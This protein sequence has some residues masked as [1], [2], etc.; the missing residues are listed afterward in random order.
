LTWEKY[1]RFKKFIVYQQEGVM[2]VNT[3]GVLLGAW[4][5][6]SGKENVVLDAGS[7][8]GI[9][10]LMLLQRGCKNVIALD[11][12]EKA[13]FQTRENIFT[14][15]SHFLKEGIK[16]E[17]FC[18][19]FQ[20]FAFE[21]KWKE[22]LDLVVS[23]PPYYSGDLKSPD[24]RKNRH[25]HQA[26]L[27]WE[28]FFSGSFNLLKNEGRCVFICPAKDIREIEKLWM[29]KGFHCQRKTSLYYK[30]GRTHP[31]KY[32]IE[33]G[34]KNFVIETEEDT[35]CVQDENLDFTLPYRNLLKE[36]YLYF[37]S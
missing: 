35:L 12:D 26:E 4:L 31:D 23:N 25:R 29:K 34:K 36:F 24:N 27:G 16:A 15:N 7:G 11:S 28:D 10:A 21:D 13:Y 14:Y 17:V 5:R 18:T 1:F 8:T 37:D 20:E 19:R 3:D 30:Q 2:P 33:L 6:L 9:I 32:L 22:S